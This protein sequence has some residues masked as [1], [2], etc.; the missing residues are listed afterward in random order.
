MKKKSIWIFAA[1]LWMLVIFLFSSQTSSQSNGLSKILIKEILSMFHIS[2]SADTFLTLN[3]IVR[4]IAHAFLYF[5]LAIFL[6]LS[7]HGFKGKHIKFFIAI[8]C[9]TF[10]LSD[11]FHQSFIAQRTP[12]FYDVIIDTVGAIIGIST[13]NL[14][15]KYRNKIN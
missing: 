4:K 11:E 5:M 6:S 1:I 15:I 2:I 9:F 3:V 10:S 8:L 13:W 14:L 7:L 12:S